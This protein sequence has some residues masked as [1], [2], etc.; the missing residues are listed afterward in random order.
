MGTRTLTSVEEY[1]QSSF[2]VDCDYVDGE[3][4]ERNLGEKDHG[5][6]QFQL[7]MWFHAR[8]KTLGTY[9]FQEQRLRV[10]PTRYRVP[11]VC[12]YIGREPEKQVFDVPPFLSVEVLSPEDRFSR[13][14][15]RLDD[16][17][18]F[19]VPHIWV[20]DPFERRAY[21]YLRG[22][23]QEV[24][25]GILRTQDPVIEVPLKDIFAAMDE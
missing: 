15:Q 17:S 3:L 24:K 13:L 9:A 20:V 18:R 8:R 6:L 22:D 2:E 5:K 12:V 23:L 16:Y 14:R 4:Q 25:D 21:T 10:S 11:D 19:G 1:L 7:M